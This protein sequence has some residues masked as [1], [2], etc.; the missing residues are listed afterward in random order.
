MEVN[1]FKPHLFNKDMDTIESKVKHTPGPWT[2]H[3]TH[4][5]SKDIWFVIVDPNGRGPI[6]DVGG[7][8]AKGQIAEAKYL[9]TSDEEIEANAKLIAAAPNLL[10]CLL[11]LD[12]ALRDGIPVEKDDPFHKIIKDLIKKAE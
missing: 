1:Q 4:H 7:N 8:E 6:V 3:R 9:V 5:L 2:Y 10:K 11:M 12:E